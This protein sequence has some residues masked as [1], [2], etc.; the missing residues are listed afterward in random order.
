VLLFVQF[1]NRKFNGGAC[2]RQP[3]FPLTSKNCQQLFPTANDVNIY[4]FLLERTADSI[5]LTATTD[6]IGLDESKTELLDKLLQFN[7]L[8]Q[9]LFVGIDDAKN[10]GKTVWMEGTR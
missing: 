6:S 4:L 10:F 8:P 5:V 7:D 3:K 1:V 2:G 9:F